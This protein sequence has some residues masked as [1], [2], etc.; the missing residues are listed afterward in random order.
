MY[1]SNKTNLRLLRRAVKKQREAREALGDLEVNL[2]PNEFSEQ[3]SDL[4][5]EEIARYELNSD[6]LDIETLESLIRTLS[7]E[8]P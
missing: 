1:K 2:S 3:M 8:A 4:L 6:T 7:Q 5:G